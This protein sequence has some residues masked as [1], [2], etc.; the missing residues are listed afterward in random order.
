MKTKEQLL[1]E[2]TELRTILEILVNMYVANRGS[3]GTFPRP[4]EFI[5]C[6]TPRHAS[7]MTPVE[8][9][10]DITWSAWDAARIAL[11]EK[12]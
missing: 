3:D 6:I 2:N 11:G 8:R 12:L 5:C 1:R 9:R 7:D 4:N 10:L